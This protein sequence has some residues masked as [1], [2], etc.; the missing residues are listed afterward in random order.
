MVSYPIIVLCKYT[1]MSANRFRISIAPLTQKRGMMTGVIKSGRKA[2]KEGDVSVSVSPVRAIADTQIGD[3]FSSLTGDKEEVLPE[4]YIQLKRDIIGSE[5]NQAALKKSW[6]SLTKRLSA[7]A[8][9]VE[10]RQQAVSTCV[11]IFLTSQCIPEV[12][13]EELVNSPTKDT[14]DRIRECGTVVVRGVVA[15]KQVRCGTGELADQAGRTV[16]GRFEDLHQPKS[17]D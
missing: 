3:V 13:Y 1:K 6:A 14:L 2:K 16:V 5:T 10:E 12:T 4:S 15:E 11:G 17:G 7:L 9:Q 8:D